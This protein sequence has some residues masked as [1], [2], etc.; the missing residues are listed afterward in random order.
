MDLPD[1]PAHWH[2]AAASFMLVICI[3]PSVTQHLARR[4]V[5][6]S[7]DRAKRRRPM[8]RH[9]SLNSEKVDTCVLNDLNERTAGMDSERALRY[10]MP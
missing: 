6:P 1:H 4:G 9:P 5:D 8:E 2:V 7:T 3:W 10:R